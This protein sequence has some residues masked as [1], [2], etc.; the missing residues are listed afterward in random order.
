MRIVQEP[1]NPGVSVVTDAVRAY[2]A[3]SGAAV[4]AEGIET[5]AHHER[6]VALGATLGQGWLYGRPSPFGDTSPCRRPAPASSSAPS[7]SSAPPPSRSPRR[8][9]RRGSAPRATCSRAPWPS[10]GCCPSATSRACCSGP[11]R[12]RSASRRPRAAGYAELA[13]GEAFVG[14]LG[15]GLGEA[16]APGVRGASLGANETL[17]DEWNV[18]ALGPT[19]AVALIAQDLGDRAATPTPLPLR[20]GRRS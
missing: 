1:D 12:P 19:F 9:P 8:R 4:L 14:A 13:R 7:R 11:S 10:S 18:I 5:E 15:V 3:E 20:L 2:A 6:A 17:A 16:P